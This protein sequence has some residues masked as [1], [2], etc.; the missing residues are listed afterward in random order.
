M[1]WLAVMLI[2]E[3]EQKKVKKRSHVCNTS[4]DDNIDSLLLFTYKISMQLSV[5]APRPQIVLILFDYMHCKFLEK[6]V[7]QVKLLNIS[8]KNKN[9]KKT[10]LMVDCQLFDSSMTK[11]CYVI[12]AHAALIVP[13]RCPGHL[14]EHVSSRPRL[15]WFKFSVVA[16]VKCE[17]VM[18]WS[19]DH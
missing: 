10:V 5:I 9:K 18:W 6:Q 2:W 14:N 1:L 17:S 4:V 8:K 11:W 13:E 3:N 15:T 12:N 16:G 19:H 7:F